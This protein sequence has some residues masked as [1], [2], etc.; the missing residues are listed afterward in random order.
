MTAAI[1]AGSAKRGSI[2]ER[3]PAQG[4]ADKTPLAANTKT[5][6]DIR[7]ACNCGKSAVRLA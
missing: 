4:A 5:L 7:V 1:R 6:W 3:S 2:P